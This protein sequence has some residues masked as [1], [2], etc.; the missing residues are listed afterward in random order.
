LS[1][2]IALPNPFDPEGERILLGDKEFESE[3]EAVEWAAEI[4]CA[5]EEG[6]VQVVCEYEDV[7]SDF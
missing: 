3:D 2:V 7:D 6:R 4:L 1:F 5:D